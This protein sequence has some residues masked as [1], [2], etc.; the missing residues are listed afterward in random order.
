MGAFLNEFR[1]NKTTQM[2]K[3]PNCAS[4][5]IKIRQHKRAEEGM[6]D[7]GDLVE[8]E[9]CSHEGVIETNFPEGSLDKTAFIVWD[10]VESP[11]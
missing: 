9:C 7:E 4:D 3:C 1:W 2:G 10:Q 6:W 11:V 8:C 5:V